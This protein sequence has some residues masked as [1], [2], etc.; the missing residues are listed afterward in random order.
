MAGLFSCGF[1]LLLLFA[2]FPVGLRERS[3]SEYLVRAPFVVSVEPISQSFPQF[4]S[5]SVFLQISDAIIQLIIENSPQEVQ[6]GPLKNSPSNFTSS[7]ATFIP[8][9]LSA[10]NMSEPLLPSDAS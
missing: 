4:P 2:L 10:L 1:G 3:I 7:M 5:C 9:M 6:I 8:V